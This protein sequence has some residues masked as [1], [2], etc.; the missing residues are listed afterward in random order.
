MIP[1]EVMIRFSATGS[2]LIIIKRK[3]SGKK[4]EKDQ[5]GK[6]R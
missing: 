3:I 2:L 5:K 6:G 4:R 1:N